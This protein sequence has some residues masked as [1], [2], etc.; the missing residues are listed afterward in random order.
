MIEFRAGF[1][2]EFSEINTQ[3]LGIFEKKYLLILK[4]FDNTVSTACCIDI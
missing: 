2:E 1:N 4:L 3:N